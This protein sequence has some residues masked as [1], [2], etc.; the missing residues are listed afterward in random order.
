MPKPP[1][2]ESRSADQSS[3]DYPE[4]W[5][6]LIAFDKNGTP[7]DWVVALIAYYDGNGHTVMGERYHKV[8]EKY[9]DYPALLT[10]LQTL[11]RKDP[12]AFATLLRELAEDS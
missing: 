12:M 3:N 2:K 6:W 8:S 5:D 10:E 1:E 4:N 9:R 11:A 7:Q